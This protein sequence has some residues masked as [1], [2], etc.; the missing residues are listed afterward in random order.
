ML[1]ICMVPK[2]P[3]SRLSALMLYEVLRVKSRNKTGGKLLGGTGLIN[4]SFREQISEIRGG[5]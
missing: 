5:L 1:V 2:F 3:N 4:K